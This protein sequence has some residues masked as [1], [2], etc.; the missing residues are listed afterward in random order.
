MYDKDAV[1]YAAE[2]ANCLSRCEAFT[3]V[4]ANSLGSGRVS[5]AGSGARVCVCVAVFAGARHES[6]LRSRLQRP[7]QTD[8]PRPRLQCR[9]HLRRPSRQNVEPCHGLQA[10]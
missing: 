3:L 5:C 6:S 9:L 10:I 4:C 8:D 7:S 1:D 2:P